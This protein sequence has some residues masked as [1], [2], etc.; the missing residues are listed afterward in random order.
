MKYVLLSLKSITKKD[1][2][3]LKIILFLKNNFLYNN[4]SY[5]RFR[6]LNIEEFL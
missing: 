3:E 6:G 1:K 5:S 4:V 2:T